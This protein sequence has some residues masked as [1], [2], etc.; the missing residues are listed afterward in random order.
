[1]TRPRPLKVVAAVVAACALTVTA[2]C[3]TH[4]GDAAVVGS[5]H[6][7]TS[8]VDDVASALCAAQSASSQQQG[9]P[10]QL[11]SRAARQGA[12]R[13]LIDARIATQYGDSL[14]IKPDQ[15]QVDAA[16]QS[17][18]S[19]INAVSGKDRTVLRDTITEVVKG[20]LVLIE[21]GRRELIRRGAKPSQ[22]TGQVALQAGT[23][24]VAGWA[25]KH[26]DVAVDPRFGT[27]S[28]GNLQTGSGSLSVPVSSRSKDTTCWSWS[29]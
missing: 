3:D 18:E 21:I 28:K 12:L 23:T 7:T 6:L 2:A 17:Q 22:I 9:Q 29:P 15:R 1:V 4:P 27:F 5:D 8:H 19:T 13:L 14:G 24:L 11:A 26:V 25:A 20:Q 10:Q 16:L